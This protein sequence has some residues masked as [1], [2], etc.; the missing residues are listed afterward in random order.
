MNIAKRLLSISLL[1]LSGL[2]CAADTRTALVIGSNDYE[3]V[4]LVNSVNDAKAMAAKLKSLGF[5]VKLLLDANANQ[6]KQSVKDFAEAISRKSQTIALLY[7]SGHGIQVSDRNILLGTDAKPP[8]LQDHAIDIQRYLASIKPGKDSAYLV[9]LDACRDY[10]AAKDA[11]ALGVLDAPPGTLI[12]L[13]TSPGRRASDG[14]DDAGNGLYTKHLLRHIATPGLQ[15]DQVMNRVR[16]A[17]VEESENSTN[18]Q[19]PWTNTS[20]LRDLYLVGAPLGM[21]VAAAPA[22]TPLRAAT[23]ALIQEAVA[24]QYQLSDFYQALSAIQKSPGVSM[25]QRS[26]VNALLEKAYQ[27]RLTDEELRFIARYQ[28]TLG[29]FALKVPEF[30]REAYGLEPGVGG[31]VAQSDG[32]GVAE[33]LG[34]LDGDIVIEFN[35]RKLVRGNDF[36]DLLDVQ[37]LPPGRIVQMKFLRQGQL[38]S[39]EAVLER[40]SPAALIMHLVYEKYRAGDKARVKSLMEGLARQEDPRALGGMARAYFYDEP[41]FTGRKYELAFQ[42]AQRAAALGDGHGESIEA[43]AY[44]AGRGV[45]EDKAQAVRL[46]QLSVEKGRLWSYGVLA[47]SYREGSGVPRDYALAKKYAEEG[48]FRGDNNSTFVLAMIY[49]K[50]LGVTKDVETALRWFERTAEILR[51]FDVQTPASKKMLDL[52]D[53]HMMFLKKFGWTIG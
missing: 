40:N 33:Q 52:I 13:S 17:V 27:L 22:D 8:S 49:A 39:A 21:P 43:F 26:A 42:L 16:L 48:A 14:E 1:L 10:V 37:K 30:I 15:I 20:L 36:R 25:E 24:P 38:R 28:Q 31:I 23:R 44:E 47:R 50:G 12:S 5:E 46:F 18:P 53:G 34:L 45:S 11:G 32:S 29:F 9:V 19:V 41:E 35:G 3:A 2:A 51:N 4:P 6:L 7:F